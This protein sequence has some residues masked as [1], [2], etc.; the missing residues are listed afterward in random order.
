MTV[1]TRKNQVQSPAFLETVEEITRL[2]KSL[3]SR[4]S[5]EEV[6]AAISVIKTVNNEEQARLD[7][8]G[9]L[10]CPQDV[11]QELFS[12][13][14]QARKTAVLFQSH[15][16]RKEALY[17]VEADKIIEKFDG[18]IQRISLLVSGDTQKEKLI[19]ISESVEKTEKESVV[20]DL[21]RA[22][23]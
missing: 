18:L 22:G 2:Y 16:Q 7:E 5:I 19:S 23:F 21:L 4:P 1:K 6:E 13:L 11:P 17:L 3:P 20:S 12:V 10:E 9:E 15:E 14:Q 8:F